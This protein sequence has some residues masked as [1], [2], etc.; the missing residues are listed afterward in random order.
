MNEEKDIMK[1][2]RGVIDSTL[3]EGLQFSGADFS[4]E[5]QKGIFERLS[6]IGVDYVEM[7]NPARPEILEMIANVIGPRNGR[8]VRVL[9]HIR[10]HPLDVENAAACGA[11]GVNILC[12]ADAER[13]AGIGLTREAYLDRLARNIESAQSLGLEVRVGV[14][15]FFGQPADAARDIHA[16]AE[17]SGASRIAV[18]DTL[19]RVMG[20]EVEGRIRRLRAAVRADIEIHFH[21]DLGHA[22]GNAV[23]ALQAGAN[24]V[25]VSLLGIGERTGITPLSTLLVNLYLLDPGLADR[26]DLGL[27]TEAEV[28]VARLCGIDMPPHLMTNPANGFAHK[29]GI[30]LN[31]VL[32]FGPHKYEPLPPAVIGNRRNLIIKS[33]VSGRTTEADVAEFNRRFGV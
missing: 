17:S 33:L 10:N 13:L 5:E 32:K 22:V 9:C 21:N 16:L 2:F 26:Y 25:S 27:L 8:P 4:L 23:A 6:R 29:A 19:G 24:W 11:D 12:T 18:A 7:A 1:N 28:Y 14:E 30:H 31:A 3:R 15:D 20:W